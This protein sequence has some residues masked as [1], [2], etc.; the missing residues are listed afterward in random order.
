MAE[1]LD[2]KTNLEST[3]VGVFRTAAT[4]KGGRRFS[5]SSLVVAGNRRGEV[6]IGYG[7]ANQVPPAIEK[8][9][10]E[11]KKSL[12]PVM[13]QGGT[14]PHEV[15]GRFAASRVKLAPASPGTGVIAG[16]AVRA[17]LEMAG[18]TDCLTKC[19]GSTNKQNVV[20][21]TLDALSRLRTKAEIESL[22]GVEV[23]MTEVDERLARADTLAPAERE[24]GQADAGPGA[25]ESSEP[26][27][28]PQP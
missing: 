8:A 4:V 3:T 26:T 22:R 9:Q 24:P 14:I 16:A 23:G 28:A 20:K 25:D 5:F 12:R 13:L 1:L 6:G 27:G 2:E 11:A 18:V 15:V 19:Y 21:A 17:V 7:K 10:K